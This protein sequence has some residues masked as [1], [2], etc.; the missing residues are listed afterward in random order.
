[1]AT[2]TDADWPETPREAWALVERFAHAAV[3]P[4]WAE[5]LR[6]LDEVRALKPGTLILPEESVNIRL[7]ALL[8]RLQAEA[9]AFVGACAATRSMMRAHYRAFPAWEGPDAVP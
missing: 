4:A 9:A 3:G 7:V 5:V 1:M 2:M 6:T 8:A